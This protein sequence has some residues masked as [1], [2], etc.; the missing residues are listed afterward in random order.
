VDLEVL[1]GAEVD[2][3]T[4][5]DSPDEELRLASY[6]QRGAYL[7]VETPY[8]PLSRHFEELLFEVAL[9]GFALVLAHP[10]RNEAFQADLG[11]AARLAEGGTVLQVTASSLL[12]RSASGRAGR[13]LVEAGH[14][15]LI[16]SDTHGVERYG[17]V[18]L[19]AGE[20]AAHELAP[21]RASWM[22]RGG[23]AAVL[24]GMPLDPPPTGRR[25]SGLSRLLRRGR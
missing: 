25:P 7:L 16:A 14:A 21:E 11:R 2:L 1:A 9:R 6:G 18:S 10:E 23:P 8:T 20:R 5:A 13:A 15:H 17:R 22:V 19:S 12:E 24:A 4:A 3:L